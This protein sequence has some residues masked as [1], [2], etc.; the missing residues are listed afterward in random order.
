M[1]RIGIIREDKVPPDNRVPFSPLQ[2]KWLMKHFP[3]IRLI[4][5]PSPSRC[6]SDTEYEEQGIRLSENMEECD[7]LF[8]I[9]EVPPSKLI[10]GKTYLFFSHTRKK[11]PYNQRLF[12]ELIDRKITLIDYECFQYENKQR[13]LGFGYFAGIIGAHN[14]LL[15]YGKRTGLFNLERAVDQSS[16]KDLLSLYQH[17]R[18][19]EMKIAVTG[20]GRVASGVLDLMDVLKIKEVTPLSY[21]SKNF[22]EPVFTQLK[23]GD[24]YKHMERNKFVREDFFENAG[25]YYCQF[26]PY[27]KTTDILINGIYWDKEIPKL[28]EFDHI[29]AEDFRIQTIADITDDKYGSVPCNL[30]DSTIDDPVYGIDRQTHKKTAPYLP[31]SLDIMAVGNLPNELPREASEHFGNQL[32]KNIFED[33][34][35]GGSPVIERATM[36]QKGDITPQFEY[37]TDYA[38][39]VPAS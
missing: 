19:P 20:S 34:I 18:L 25:E 36:V 12:Q 1:L 26:H 21:Q 7:I 24:L 14:G 39:G 37:L 28:F 4:V 27:T 8:G 11:Q 30:G 23:G 5:Q 17:I 2:C 31:G 32:L 15:A 6:F 29:S 33:L 3:N 38:E 22:R 35:T 9:K 13:I 10:P 16:Y